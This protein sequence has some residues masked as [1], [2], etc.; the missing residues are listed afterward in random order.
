MA[1]P[2]SQDTTGKSRWRVP[3]LIAE[4]GALAVLVGSMSLLGG[5]AEEGASLNQAWLLVPA[6][7]SLVVFV[8]FLGLMYLR[9]VSE[10]G[11]GASRQRI[12]FALLALTLLGVWA[13]GIARTWQSMG[14]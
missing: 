10:A 9:W 2:R 14:Q 4:F 12:I 13:F 3:L 5:Q 1:E 6:L 7:A 8:S 11:N